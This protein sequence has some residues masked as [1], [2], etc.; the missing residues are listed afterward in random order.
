MYLLLKYGI[1]SIG[2][3]FN[4]HIQYHV[5]Y[6]EM[7]KKIYYMLKTDILMNSSQKNLSVLKGD[8]SECGCPNGAQTPCW[9]RLWSELTKQRGVVPA[10]VSYNG[11]TWSSYP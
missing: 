11:S 2:I 3:G 10:M 4:V 6:I 5:D 8:F 9:L 7:K 1:M